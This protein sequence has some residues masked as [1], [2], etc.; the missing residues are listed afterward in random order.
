MY[1]YKYIYVCVC[2]R[3]WE[4]F[5]EVLIGENKPATA[6]N[7]HLFSRLLFPLWGHW[8]AGTFEA[9]DSG[10]GG[11]GGGTLKVS[12][13]RRVLRNPSTETPPTA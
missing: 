6:T 4:H 8:V 1:A 5:L 9:S 7:I 13:V 10:G 11:V 12:Y 2:V 3:A